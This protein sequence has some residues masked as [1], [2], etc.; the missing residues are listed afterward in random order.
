MNI[1]ITG[2]T[3]FR[4]R[5]VEAL[6]RPTVE[7]LTSRYENA[8]I[9]I[10]TWSSAYD[11]VRLAAP[12]TSYLHDSFPQCG[13]WVPKPPPSLLRMAGKRARQKL[14][15]D[16]TQ[17]SHEHLDE[18]LAMPFE[19]PDLLVIS[20][21][22]I[23][24]SDYGTG[25][26]SHFTAP[27][28]WARKND[29]PV[30][31]L[32]QSVGRFKCAED[33]AIWRQ[34]E[35]AASL[36]T[37]RESHSKEYLCK[38]L[39]S[40]A[41]RLPVTADTAFLLAADTAVADAQLQPNDKPWVAVSISESISGWTGVDYE[42]HR[43]AWGGLIRLMLEKW[44]VRVAIIPHVQELKGDDRIVSSRVLRDLGF[45]HRVRLFAEDLSAAE[46]KGLISRCDLV[47]AE[48]M[49]AAIAGLSTG[50]C[51]MPVSY[52]IKAEG[53]TSAVLEGSGLNAMD[54]VV[55]T[56]DLLD[57]QAVFA[58][59]DRVW[60]QRQEYARAIA[61]GAA[62]QKVLALQNFDKINEILPQAA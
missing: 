47:I 21:G 56:T 57:V 6:V 59:M 23:F 14:G 12:R 3:G 39:N 5:G 27:V 24:S 30:V 32:G 1:V 22:D 40:P 44:D 33:E 49:H 41:D 38:H 7:Q 20:G 62:R 53:I 2:V 16:Q 29:V 58:K 13:T 28:H 31:L 48:R 35:D 61:Q 46:F 4:N 19:R 43:A 8:S 18:Q 42:K 36:V 9:Q 11:A 34:T 60:Q 17:T 37:L 51:T 50:R 52:S 26:L 45:D 25:S 55:P 15:I 54:L 10:V